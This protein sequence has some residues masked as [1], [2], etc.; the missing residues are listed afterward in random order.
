MECSQS[1]TYLLLPATSEHV[2]SKEG[3]KGLELEHQIL[4]SSAQCRE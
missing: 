4:G 2:F 1:I 3:K